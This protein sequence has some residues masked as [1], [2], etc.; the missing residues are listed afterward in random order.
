[1]WRRVEG[2]GV[3]EVGARAR[4]ARARRGARKSGAACGRGAF[5]MGARARRWPSWLKITC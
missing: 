3:C 2:G 5:R 4:G 1:M